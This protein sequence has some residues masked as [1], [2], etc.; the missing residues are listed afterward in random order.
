MNYITEQLKPVTP[1]IDPAL[2][3]KYVA[4]AKRTCY[5][6]LSEEAKTALIAYY[7][8]L[9]D[10]ADSSK[11]VPVTARQLEALV[12]LAEAS[13]RVRLSPKILQVGCGTGDQDCR[14]LPQAGGIRCKE[15]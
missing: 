4:Y 5:P 2:F 14:Y 15:R 11:P 7:M 13:A 3:R 1:T 8:N 10:I 6:I 12:R 9:R